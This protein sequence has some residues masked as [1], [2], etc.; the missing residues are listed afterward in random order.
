MLKF[1]EVSSL[2][3]IQAELEA[4]LQDQEQEQE[5]VRSQSGA[6]GQSLRGVSPQSRGARMSRVARLDLADLSFVT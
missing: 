3:L 4:A 5:P 6:L 2:L 1:Y